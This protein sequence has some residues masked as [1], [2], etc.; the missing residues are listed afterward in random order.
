MSVLEIAVRDLAAVFDPYYVKRYVETFRQANAGFEEYESESIRKE[1]K[2]KTISNRE[3]PVYREWIE[4]KEEFMGIHEQAQLL[5][6][7]ITRLKVAQ[8]ITKIDGD[9]ETFQFPNLEQWIENLRLHRRDHRNDQILRELDQWKVRVDEITWQTSANDTFSQT[10]KPSESA[11]N[12]SNTS[13]HQSRPSS[14]TSGH[15]SEIRV[16]TLQGWLWPVSE[17]SN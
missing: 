16:S 9:I 15:W 2:S 5:K 11:G 10:S 7:A 14:E 4:T 3:R 1:D 13:S 12:T 17:E 8:C 6:K